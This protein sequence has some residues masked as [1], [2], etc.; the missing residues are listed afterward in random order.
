MYR[1]A[2][3]WQFRLYAPCCQCE[4]LTRFSLVITVLPDKCLMGVSHLMRRQED[5]HE[6]LRM[7]LDAAER[8]EL[9][10]LRGP[11][12]IAGRMVAAPPTQFHTQKFARI[13]EFLSEAW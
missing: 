13:H 10:T 1:S 3:T 2:F 8:D 4:L 9:H 7:L 12:A 5:A 6:F 11:K